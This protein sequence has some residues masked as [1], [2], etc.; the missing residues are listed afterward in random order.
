MVKQMYKCEQNSRMDAQP[1]TL[2]LFLYPPL[3]KRC[4]KH[5]CDGGISFVSREKFRSSPR[6]LMKRWWI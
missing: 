5:T 3:A 1:H 2:T 4:N 6:N